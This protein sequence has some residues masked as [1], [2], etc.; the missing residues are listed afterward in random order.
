MPKTEDHEE[1]NAH[2]HIPTESLET[3]VKEAGLNTGSQGLLS[4][5]GDPVGM[6]RLIPPLLTLH[7]LTTHSR[8]Q[9]SWY[10]SPS[11]RRRPRI[12]RNGTIGGSL[13]RRYARYTWPVLGKEGGK[14]GDTG[15]GEQGEQ[16]ARPGELRRI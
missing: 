5:V 4:Q 6:T 13:G 11:A 7:L 12:G 1:Q 14:V 9:H 16:E 8:R 2:Q 10:G 3:Q 15:W